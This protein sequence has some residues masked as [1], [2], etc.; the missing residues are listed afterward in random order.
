[1]LKKLL[2]VLLTIFGV[3]TKSKELSLDME[4]NNLD[5]KEFNTKLRLE[6]FSWLCNYINNSKMDDDYLNRIDNIRR[7]FEIT[8]ASEDP[9]MYMYNFR[10]LNYVRLINVLGKDVFY[11]TFKR[12]I[13]M[14]I[15]YQITNYNIPDYFPILR[16]N[17]I[18]KDMSEYLYRYY[19]DTQEKDCLT[20]KDFINSMNSERLLNKEKN[21][22]VMNPMVIS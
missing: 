15:H 3:N 4:Y 13:I 20:T 5:D 1:M 12:E 10:K 22:L 2:I 7:Y 17:K 11:K 21:A 14:D 9:L 8:T 6:G 16:T 19:L 18:L